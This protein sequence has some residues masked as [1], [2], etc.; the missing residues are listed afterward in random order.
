MLVALV[1]QFHR[2]DHRD[3]AGDSP[4]QLLGEEGVRRTEAFTRHHGRSR[5]DHH[6]AHKNQQHGDGKQPAVDTHALRHG[7]FISP[8]S[9]EECL[10]FDC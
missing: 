10:N 6:Q 4:D 9:A 8:R 1:I 3:Q 2:N 7:T 5:K